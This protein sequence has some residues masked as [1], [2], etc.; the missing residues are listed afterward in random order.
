MRKKLQVFIL[1]LLLFSAFAGNGAAVQHKPDA[2][3]KTVV[4]KKAAQH[5]YRGSSTVQVRH[6]DASALNRF[7]KDPQFNYNDREG[8]GEMS[9]LERV[10]IW[11][12]QTLFGW[13]QH[14]HVDGTWMGLFLTILKY[15]FYAAVVALVVFVVIKAI[16]LDV[17]NLFGRKA[18]QI[19]IPY[20]EAIEDI[21]AIDFDAELEKALAQHNYRLAVRLLY[22]HALKQLDSL[23]LIRWQMDK[24]N[25]AYIN[26]LTDPSQKQVFGLITRQ[27]EY[28]WYGNFNIDKQSFI[29]I[30]QL[31]NDFKQ[32][33]P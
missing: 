31:F 22:L 16:G 21:N 3:K 10:W 32:Q 12:M 17:G 18:K 33:L 23:Q 1:L 26:E 29:N 2:A 8:A 6:F 4:V 20:S 28:V 5:I 25:A 13:M 24:T 11:L 9:F 7:K 14:A 30:S 19:D 27:F 15:L